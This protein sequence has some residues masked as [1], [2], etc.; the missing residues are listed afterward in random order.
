MQCCGFGSE[1]AIRFALPYVLTVPV[2]RS[3]VYSCIHPRARNSAGI[4]NPFINLQSPAAA[5]ASL[6]LLAMGAPGLEIW[7][8]KERD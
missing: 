8:R 6:G 1:A 3:N 2:N 4:S 5:P 7:R